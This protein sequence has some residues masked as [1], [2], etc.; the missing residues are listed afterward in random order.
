MAEVDRATSIGWVSYSLRQAMGDPELRNTILQYYI[1]HIPGITY[2]KTFD[3]Y[4]KLSDLTRYLEIVA[5]TPGIT[6][7]TATNLIDPKAKYHETHF[8]TFIVSNIRKT[9]VTI[10]PAMKP[11]GE[12]GI[13]TPYITL[14]VIKPFFESKGYT[15]HPVSVKNVCQKTDKDVFCQSWS[16]YLQIE[17]IKRDTAQIPIPSKQGDK[18]TLLLSFFKDLISIPE[19]CDTL[20]K[21]YTNEIMTNKD[22]V[23]GTPQHLHKALRAAYIARNP[24][25]ILNDMTSVDMMEH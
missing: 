4:Y 14:E 11:N 6:L 20:N 13:Y 7:F 23:S 1:G 5:N 25:Q 15:V 17:A 22:F 24:C 12:E 10:D 16:L 21:V 9:V 2:G 19:F 8:Q 18:Y 3:S